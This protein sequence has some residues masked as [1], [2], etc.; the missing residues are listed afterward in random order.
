MRNTTT[1]SVSIRRLPDRSDRVK[2]TIWGP[3]RLAECRIFP[4]AVPTTNVS[5]AAATAVRSEVVPEFL[6]S[7]AIPSPEVTMVPASPTAT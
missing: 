6:T 2:E 4:E 7:Q 1:E 3:R 5:L